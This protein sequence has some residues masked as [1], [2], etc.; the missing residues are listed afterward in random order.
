MFVRCNFN[1]TPSIFSSLFLQARGEG[2]T[3][4]SSQECAKEENGDERAIL[5]SP[6]LV[7]SPKKKAADEGLA[8]IRE[9]DCS[10]RNPRDEPQ[11][12]GDLGNSAPQ[13]V[14]KGCQRG[15]S[16]DEVRVQPHILLSPLDDN[17]DDD[18]DE[19]RVP[20]QK[21]ASSPVS[22]F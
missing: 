17:D 2:V 7:S 4:K 16:V 3:A 11:G 22:R 20:D 12:G 6:T 8:D 13:R 14:S 19:G 1:F 21:L 10:H 9:E 15:M 18:Y 5:S